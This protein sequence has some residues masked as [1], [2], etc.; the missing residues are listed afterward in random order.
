MPNRSLMFVTLASLGFAAVATAQLV[1]PPPAANPQI[2]A[3]IPKAPPPPPAAEIPPSMPPP[4]RATPVKKEPVPAL[5]YK[6]WEKDTN[7]VVLPL[8]EPLELAA[9]RRNPYMTPEM[10]SKMEA[11]LPERKKSVRRVV[12]DNLDLSEQLENAFD[13][14]TLASGDKSGVGDLMRVTK[15]LNVTRLAV[16]LKNRGIIDDKA[17]GFNSQ[18]TSAYDKATSPPAKADGGADKDRINAMLRN[19][20]RNTMSEQIMEYNELLLEASKELPGIKADLTRDEKIAAVKQAMSSMTLDQRKDLLRKVA[21][22][23]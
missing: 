9:L 13:K 23:S 3:N 2:D 12:I 10:Q 1:T 18:I 11:Y 15:P 19:V 5:P 6:E 7:G 16:D 8:N 4:V 21:G 14:V 22:L 17:A 20:L